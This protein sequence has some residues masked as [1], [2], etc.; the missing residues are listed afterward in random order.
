[1]NKKIIKT[2]KAPQ[3]IGVYS[4][5]IEIDN[6]IFTSGQI[7]LTCDGKLIDGNFKLES[8]QVINNI[9]AILKHSG[10]DLSDIIKITIYLTDLSLFP[11]LN[12]VFEEF[13]KEKPPA[14]STVEVSALPMNVRIEMEA[15]ALKK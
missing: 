11:K 12:E 7:P 2:T 14:R 5:G 9:Q 10:L 3:A 15:I 8:R 4:Q 1:M 13:F 6:L